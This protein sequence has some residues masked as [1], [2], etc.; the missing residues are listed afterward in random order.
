LDVRSV[1]IIVSAS[2]QASA[3]IDV[4]KGRLCLVADSAN[5]AKASSPR[6]EAGGDNSSLGLS[7]SDRDD[8]DSGALAAYDYKVFDRYRR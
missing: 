3:A 1:A 4:K 7:D 6:L 2:Q 8:G 5:K